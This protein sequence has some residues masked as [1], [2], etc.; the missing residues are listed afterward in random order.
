MEQR[1]RRRREGEKW[2]FGTLVAI[3]G[4]E[5]AAVVVVWGVARAGRRWKRTTCEVV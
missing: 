3:E 5:W 2:R 1:E 4:K